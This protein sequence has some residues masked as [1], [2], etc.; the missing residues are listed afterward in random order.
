V[1]AI[2][3]RHARKAGG[4][5]REEDAGA[6]REEDAHAICEEDACAF[7]ARGG[8]FSITRRARTLYGALAA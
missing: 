6:I 2:R 8:A 5:A 1:G 4:D 7:H 3:R